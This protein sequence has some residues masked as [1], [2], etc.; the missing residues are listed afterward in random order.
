[1][2]TLRYFALFAGLAVAL[3]TAAAVH[4]APPVHAPPSAPCNSDHIMDLFITDD[5]VWFECVCERL[6]MGL[7]CD[8]YELGP[9]PDAKAARNRL[10]RYVSPATQRQLMVRHNWPRFLSL[11]HTSKPAAKVVAGIATGVV[12]TT[13]A[14]NDPYLADDAWAQA[15]G[16]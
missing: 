9:A 15:H 12:T 14:C 16:C 3:V 11:R 8:W 6:P 1:M 7:V 2:S 10:W 13:G 4:A 5:G